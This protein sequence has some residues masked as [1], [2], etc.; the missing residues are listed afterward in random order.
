MDNYWTRARTSRRR[1]LAGG[2]GIAASLAVTSL[3]GAGCGDDDDDDEQ[4]TAGAG[5]GA[6]G[7]PTAAANTPKVG[8]ELTYAA[9]LEPVDA[10]PITSTL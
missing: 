8:G 6:A 9:G 10:N 7:S 5:T 3:L 4:P 1:I 2:T